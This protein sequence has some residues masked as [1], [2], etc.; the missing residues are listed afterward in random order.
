MTP[1]Q[2][3]REIAKIESEADEAHAEN[4][5]GPRRNGRRMLDEH[6]GTPQTSGPQIDEVFLEGI[7]RRSIERWNGDLPTTRN[8]FLFV[9]TALVIRT[10]QEAAEQGHLA[11]LIGADEQV[12]PKTREVIA[13]LVADFMYSRDPQRR[14]K[15]YDFVFGLCIQPGI[16]ESEIARSEGVCRAAISKECTEIKEMFGVRPS[17]GMKSDHACDTYRKRELQKPRKKR[18]GWSHSNV[19]KGVIKCTVP[20][21]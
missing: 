6:G 5:T 15:C 12:T 13:R 16:S 14:A 11:L 20:K 3:L 1:A 2:R 17:R 8:E 10:I 19:I 7:L 9:V 21:N 4:A 18:T